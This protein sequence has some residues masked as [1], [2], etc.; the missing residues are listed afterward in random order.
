E[1]LPQSAGDAERNR[2]ATGLA[3]VFCLLHDD[4]GQERML[5]DLTSRNA[6]DRASREALYS[7]A[8]KGGDSGARA[9]WREAIRRIEGQGGRT[10]EVLDALHAAG[11]PAG[12]VAELVRIALADAPDDPDAHLLAARLAERRA[13]VAT[14]VQQYELAA[15]LDPAAPMYQEAR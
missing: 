7:L 10:V 3:E 6:A 8:L 13:D 15:D 14:A 12:D 2:L 4:A 1:A 9:R 5:T 11:S